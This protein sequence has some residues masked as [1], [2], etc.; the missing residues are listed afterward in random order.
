M[1]RGKALTYEE[2]VALA[3]ENY[4]KGGDVAVEC[5]EQREFDF[6]VKE[7]GPV[8]KTKAMRMFRQWK[9]EEKEQQAMMFGEI[10]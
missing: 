1:A 8:T 5:W 4:T 10:W 3:K 6:Y 9:D 2:F 7:F